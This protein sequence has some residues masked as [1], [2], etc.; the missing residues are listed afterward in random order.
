MMAI[1]SFFYVK[2]RI[3]SLMVGVH[4]ATERSRKLRVA[5]WLELAIAMAIRLVITVRQWKSA[6]FFSLFEILSQN[7]ILR[8]KNE[9]SK[10]CPQIAELFL[11]YWRERLTKRLMAN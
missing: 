8:E 7:S 3:H 9:P 6:F 11:F 5:R 2:M 4:C 10:H 1:L